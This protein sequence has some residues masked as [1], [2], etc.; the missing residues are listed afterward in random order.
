M[1]NR[2]MHWNEQANTLVGN[3]TRS[4]PVNDLIKIVK[5]K[6]VR[7]QSKPSKAWKLFTKQEYEAAIQKMDRYENFEVRVFVLSIFI[8][9]MK[10]VAVIDDSSKLLSENLKENQHQSRYSIRS[11]ILWS[12]IF[13]EERDAPD[14]IFIGAQ[15]TSYCILITFW[16]WIELFISKGH[17]ENTDFA[18]GIHGKNEP[19]LIKEKA[20]DFM[21]KIINDDDLSLYLKVSVGPIASEIWRL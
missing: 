19:I 18:F 17:M 8:L 12:K 16:T 10:M 21:I 15:N 11:R 9:Q 1:L 4:I 5:N 13:N 20:D 2:L 7:K 3:A 14:Q 6:E